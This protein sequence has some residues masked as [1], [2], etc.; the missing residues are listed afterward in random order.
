MELEIM[1]WLVKE[2]QV[3]ATVVF[4]SGRAYDPEFLFMWPNAQISVMG[5][6]Q[7]AHVDCSL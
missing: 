7:A 1:R 2:I 5:A 3:N 4:V 6:A